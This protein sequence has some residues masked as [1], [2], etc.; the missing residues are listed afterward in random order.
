[1]PLPFS[2][3]YRLNHSGSPADFILVANSLAQDL[4][5]LMEADR[6]AN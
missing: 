1:M 6:G 5:V 4:G 2:T 3:A